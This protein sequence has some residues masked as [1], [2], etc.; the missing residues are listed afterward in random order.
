MLPMLVFVAHLF[1]L[2]KYVSLCLPLSLFPFIF[3]HKASFSILL[4]LMVCP[5]NFICLFLMVL[6]SSLEVPA[7]SN[8][9]SLDFFSVHKILII[10]LKNHISAA[11]NLFFAS[12]SIVQ[13]SQP[14]RRTDQTYPLSIRNLVQ[15]LMF[16]FFIM[17]ANPMKLLLDIAIFLFISLLHLP[18]CVIM[19]PRY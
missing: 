1:R 18:T 14:Y 5:R 11:S 6:M 2:S 3:P 12:L 8:T 13:H 4:L 19:Y 9:S 16:L 10:L 15:T 7:V 17:L